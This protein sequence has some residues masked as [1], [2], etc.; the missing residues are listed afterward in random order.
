MPL[1][2]S[3]PMSSSAACATAPA[4]GAQPGWLRSAS[5]GACG[6]AP[7]GAAGPG[8][9]P[10][11]RAPGGAAAAAA[12]RAAPHS[13]C[14]AGSGR[15]TACPSSAAADAAGLGPAPGSSLAPVP[16]CPP[17]AAPQSASPPA[18]HTASRAM[19][20]ASPPPPPSPPP[21]TPSCTAL[22]RAR[23]R[24]SSCQRRSSAV[25]RA[26]RKYT[27]TARRC[28]RRCA[29]SSACHAL[30]VSA[31]G[32][33][34]Q[35]RSRV[36]RSVEAVTRA[37]HGRAWRTSATS[38]GS[39]AKT[40]ALAALKSRPVPAAVTDSSAT[41]TAGSSRKRAH[42][43]LAPRGRRVKGLAAHRGSGAAPEDA[44][45]A[46][47]QGPARGEVA[48]RS[49]TPARNSHAAQHAR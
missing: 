38:S 45:R 18:S 43:D 3:A 41:R 49:A 30:P 12:E 48:H 5:G 29:R 9:A 14:C 28:P 8:A 25:P 19:P 33:A 47:V 20:P 21:P 44:A 37:R 40:T 10:A 16:G 11:A 36:R 4:K 15:G 31:R 39:S 1:W 35:L 26:I 42:A 22:T 24:L 46:R 6:P 27:L 13:S 34:V 17:T 23:L 2:P 32:W 7:A